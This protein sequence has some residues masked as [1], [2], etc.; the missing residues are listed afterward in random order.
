MSQAD[1]IRGRIM[2]AAF[3][4]FMQHGY[5]GASTADIARIAK[6]SKRDLYAHFTSKQAMLEAC[7][8]DRAETMR[9]PLNLPSP[10]NRAVLREMLIQYGMVVVRELSKPEVIAT[11]RLAIMNAETAPDVAQTLDRCGRGAATA[12]LVDL[13]C[14]AAGKGLVSGAEPS[15]MAEV[16][17]GVLTQT[18]MLV[19]LMMRVLETPDETAIRGRAVLATD[20]LERLYG[21]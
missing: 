19:R 12:G 10:P 15:Q 8:R 20:V 5:E 11:F 2:D 18:S 7:I 13:L 1:T 6:V 14:A 21:V 4:A 9:Q 17:L 16:F 3:A